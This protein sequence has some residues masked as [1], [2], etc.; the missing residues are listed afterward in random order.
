MNVTHTHIFTPCLATLHMHAEPHPSLALTLAYSSAN[1]HDFRYNFTKHFALVQLQQTM[2][3][4]G[5]SRGDAPLVHRGLED[6][7]TDLVSELVLQPP[8]DPTAE[9]RRWNYVADLFAV[10]NSVNKRNHVLPGRCIRSV[11]E[12]VAREAPGKRCR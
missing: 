8:N 6:V 1:T 7:L 9:V 12:R 3:A 10:L 11:L 4:Q 2:L 5:H